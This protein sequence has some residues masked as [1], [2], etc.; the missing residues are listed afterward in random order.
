MTPDELLREAASLDSLQLTEIQACEYELL[1]TGGL[2][3]HQTY[4]AA[5]PL[6]SERALA[7]GE[8]IAL[9]DVFNE[10][11][12]VLEVQ[13]CSAGEQGY[14]VEG[15]LEVI[16]RPRWR[17][18]LPYRLTPEELKQR[19]PESVAWVASPWPTVEEELAAVERCHAT[20]LGLLAIVPS[21]Y[22]AQPDLFTRARAM[23]TVLPDQIRHELVVAPMG[24][25]TRELVE[26]VARNYGAREVIGP[27]GSTL[28]PGVAA[29]RQEVLPDRNRQGFCVWFTGLPSS[30]KSTIA[31]ELATMIEERG[32]RLTVL[33]G[34]VVRT[35][36]SK[37]LGFS[38]GDRDTNILRIGWVASEIVRHHGAVVCAAV[39]PYEGTRQRVRAMVGDERF[40][41]VHVATPQEVC[42]ERDVKGFYQ[43][44]R[45]GSLPGFTGVDDPYEEPVKPSLRLETTGTTAASNARVVADYLAQQGFL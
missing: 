38:R 3:P 26:A 6:T 2:A 20:G 40:V 17:G 30:G 31:L 15:S 10:R 11:L 41:L 9:R 25:V 43:R 32:R 16:Q 33:D 29:I 35:H 42:E 5:F 4:D 44:A 27:Q 7:A 37:G 24:Y 45:A 36:L 34:D 21:H 13:A 1:V 22:P 18:L 39:S 14:R 23:Q 12:A 19:L 8:R 28:R